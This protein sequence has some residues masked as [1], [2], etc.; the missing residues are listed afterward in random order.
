[1]NDA[2]VDE[3]IQGRL[4]EVR[5]KILRING[6]ENLSLKQLHTLKALIQEAEALT[7]GSPVDEIFK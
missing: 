7:G 3:L 5:A 1:M 6:H 2:Q 4:N